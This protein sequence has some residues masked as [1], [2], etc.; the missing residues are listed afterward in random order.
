L[1]ND[2]N[3][4]PGPPVR[5]LIIAENASE[6]YGGEAILPVRY[7]R[8]LHQRGIPTWLLTHS[9]VRPEL[10]SLLPEQ[11]NNVHF[12]EETMLHRLLWM[13]GSKFDSRLQYFTTGFILRLV[14]QRS[15][16]KIARHLIRQH[17]IAV[18]HQP[19]PVSPR[20]PSLLMGLGT[21]VI[22]G[23]MNGNM[24][25]PP[26]FR[27]E[28]PLLTRAFIAVA[29]TWADLLNNVFPGK[30]RASIL[31]VAN[32]RTRQALARNVSGKVV[33]LPENGVD[34][35]VW[36]PGVQRQSA[37]G[38]CGFIF[39]GRLIRS[40]GVDLWLEA[41]ERVLRDGTAISVT[42]VGD[43][44]ESGRLKE[45]ARSAGLLAEQAN[46][47]GKVFFAGYLPQEKVA[48]V[49][50]TQDCL[51]LPTL[52]ESGGAVLLEAMASALP[53]IA[54]DWG[55]PA[56]YVDEEC[57]ILVRPDSR[58]ALIQGLADAMQ[59]LAGNPDLRRQLGKAGRQKVE[60]CYSWE[61]KID[62]IIALYN[63]VAGGGSLSNRRWR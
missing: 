32:Q 17:S 56:D 37:A 30:R 58:E 16:L 46:Q 59:R 38:D 51:V 60:K 8:M 10:A 63:D 36:R 24:D 13:V 19:T 52:I 35:A 34:T 27:T 1:A 20:E 39:V 18:V 50:S 48:Q 29:R 7:F 4:D 49:L 9:R 28:E 47:V 21:P 3:Q 54:T 6:T 41:C 11:I 42:I 33:Y 23:P 61:G 44:P 55:G 62:R 15:Q 45:Q 25:Y 14:T 12:V 31:L 57:G 43:G 22:I 5:V 53:V 26:A 40:K 2:G